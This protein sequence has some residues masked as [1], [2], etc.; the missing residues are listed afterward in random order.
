MF[1]PFY[2]IAKRVNMI[3]SKKKIQ[4]MRGNPEIINRNNNEAQSDFKLLFKTIN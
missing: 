1:L 3:N 4:S 2:T